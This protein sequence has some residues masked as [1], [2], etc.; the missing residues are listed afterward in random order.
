[1]H[2]LAGDQVAVAPDCMH[3]T[4]AV[5]VPPLTIQA[6][7]GLGTVGVVPVQTHVARLLTGY[8][9]VNGDGAVQGDGGL[10]AQP[11]EMI[12]DEML[13]IYTSF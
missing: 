1:M 13:C 4:N 9:G 11:A 6:P 7:G 3:V 2:G 10:V 12:N 5:V 8:G